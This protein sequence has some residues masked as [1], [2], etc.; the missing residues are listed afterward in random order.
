MQSRKGREGPT[1]AQGRKLRQCSMQKGSG[2][3]CDERVVGD[4]LGG[5]G[6]LLQ[7]PGLEKLEHPD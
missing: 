4:E 6:W 5:S 2:A 3:G 1:Y 7:N